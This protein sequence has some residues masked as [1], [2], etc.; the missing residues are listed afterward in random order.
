[1]SL[2]G[3]TA[4]RHHRY[5]E[6]RACGDEVVYH[7]H[8]LHELLLFTPV[9]HGS[10]ED[11]SQADRGRYDR[12]DARSLPSQAWYQIREGSCCSFGKPFTDSSHM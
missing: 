11:P 12:A 6:L 4:T 9:R 8:E 3:A 7:G 2:V 5:T 10:E 1:M